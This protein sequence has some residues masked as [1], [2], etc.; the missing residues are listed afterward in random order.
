MKRLTLSRVFLI[1]LILFPVS[2][3]LTY[4]QEEPKVE[5]VARYNGPGNLNDYAVAI[6]VDRLGNVYVTGES[7]GGGT[8]S[9]YATVKYDRNGN[10]AW[11]ARYNGPRNLTDEAYAIAIDLLGNVYVTGRS[12]GSGTYYDYATVKYDSNGDESWVARYNGPGN[13]N[14]FAV[15]I[16]VDP[17][18]NVYVTGRSDGSG[19]YY[20]YATVKYDSNGDESWVARYNGPGN[21]N[22]DAL[23]IAVDFSGNV[24][25]TGKSQGV[26]PYDDY[27]TVK[28]DRNG[29]EAWV[30]RYNSP[31]NLHDFAEAIAIDPQGNVY[32]TGWSHGGSSL[33][34]PY[35]DY[36]TVKYDRN[37]D[38]AWVERYN[39]PGSHWDCAYAIAV[40]PLENVYVTG[41]SRGVGTSND[42]ATVKYDRN[43]NE[44]WVARYNGPGNLNDYAEAV[45]VDPQGNVYVTGWSEGSGTYYD[46][47][48]IK[49]SKY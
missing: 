26:G 2:F 8:S 17:R 15:G 29:N 14:D 18:G 46:Y 37:G 40:D 12:E 23:A 7:Y 3:H 47:A 24:Y 31:V 4:G 25:V 35:H 1:A 5:W 9:D 16:A 48:T 42:Y 34:G 32:V 41:N 22:D 13:F 49:Y 33:V 44:A 6:A 45:A 27:A 10:E 38:E 36:A 30:A 19:T 20:D 21:F 11:V 28:Y 39:G 43:G